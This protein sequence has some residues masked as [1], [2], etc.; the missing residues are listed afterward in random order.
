MSNHFS[1]EQISSYFDGEATPEERV[2]IERLLETSAEARREHDDFKK[3]SALLNTL[4]VESAPQNL[5]AIVTPKLGPVQSETVAASSPSEANQSRRSLW[6]IAG[7]LT[8]IAATLLIAVKLFDSGPNQRGPLEMADS[9]LERQ[10]FFDRQL[11]QRTQPQTEEARRLVAESESDTNRSQPSESQE[12]LTVDE[13]SKAFG[14][15]PQL[16]KKELSSQ[17]IPAAAAKRIVKSPDDTANLVQ[18]SNGLRSPLSGKHDSGLIF[19][20]L[21]ELKDADVGNI[22]TALET[23]NAGITVV[24]LT[25]VDRRAGLKTL[26]VLLSRHRI[27]LEDEKGKK[28]DSDKK[29]ESKSREEKNNS[30]RKKPERLVA[31]YVKAT[32]RQVTAALED[33]RNS[34]LFQK[35]HVRGPI[36]TAQLNC[37]SERQVFSRGSTDD[38]SKTSID[39]KKPTNAFQESGLEAEKLAGNRDIIR[40]RE[41]SPLKELDRFSRQ[42]ELSLSPEV[43]TE[44]SQTTEPTGRYS[45][46]SRSSTG[47]TIRLNSKISKPGKQNKNARTILQPDPLKVLFI[48]VVNESHTPNA[49]PA[50]KPIKKVRSPQKSPGNGAA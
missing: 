33:L 12:A 34:D 6:M 41:T 43:L 26:Q 35:L 19:E 7:S 38:D 18:D 2:E 22:V 10:D 13:E 11:S 8:A 47:F 30:T 24:K 9:R 4:P 36:Q 42:L 5:S 21:Q 29:S 15:V 45:P 16:S 39:S 31:V 37:Y 20:N 40:Q 48:L 23:T 3:L 28:S 44:L 14:V 17:S 46:N 50:I 25:V 32:P 1:D 27:P 49:S